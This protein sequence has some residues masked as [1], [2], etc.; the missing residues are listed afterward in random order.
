MKYKGVSMGTLLGRNSN[1]V[2]GYNTISMEGHVEPSDPEL[3]A[4]MVSNY[5]RVIDV[6]VET[7]TADP[8]NPN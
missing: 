1:L 5:L 3:G 7:E 8:G 2:Q 4:E 6:A